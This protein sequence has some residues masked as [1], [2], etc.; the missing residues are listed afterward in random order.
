MTTEAPL[1][2]WEEQ[3]GVWS[4]DFDDDLE[5]DGTLIAEFTTWVRRA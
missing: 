1:G 5:G 3:G 2:G 4:I